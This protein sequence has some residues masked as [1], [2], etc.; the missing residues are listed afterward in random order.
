MLFPVFKES[1]NKAKSHEKG[2]D[3]DTR[4]ELE[5]VM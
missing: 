4:I 1:V 2:S 3:T 5:S